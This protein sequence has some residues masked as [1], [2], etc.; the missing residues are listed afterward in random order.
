MNELLSKVISDWQLLHSI[1]LIATLLALAYVFLALKQSLWCWPAALLSTLLFSH[2]MWD[3][4]LLSDALL[5]L[6]Y[7]GMALYGWRRWQQYQQQHGKGQAPVFE[8]PWQWHLILVSGTAIAGL[9]LGYFMEHYTHADF[10]WLDAQ[11]T[12]FSL[13]A[14]WLV[15]QKL[16]SN[17]LYWVVIDAVSIYVY[18]QK[19]LY[20][21]T[22]LFMLYTIIALVGYF[23]W[24]SHYQLQQTSTLDPARL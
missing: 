3:S 15:A 6:Y 10:A 12:A 17:W 11:T 24:R 8:R 18:A 19:H 7:A 23:A 13:V 9:V 20:F 16:V 5:Q 2:V 1:E 4:A 22:A 14:T 21:L